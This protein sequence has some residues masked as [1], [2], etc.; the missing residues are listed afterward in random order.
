[1]RLL[2]THYFKAKDKKMKRA[3]V[4]I[5]IIALL[6]VSI[7]KYNTNS[8]T[9]ISCIKGNTASE[10][11]KLIYRLYFLGVIPLGDAV[12]NKAQ[13]ETIAGVKVY[14]LNASASTLKAYSKLGSASAVIDSYID[15]NTGNPLLFKQKVVSPGKEAAD[16]EVVYDQKNNVMTMAGERRTILPDTQDPLSLIFNIRRLNLANVGKAEYQMNTN[17]KNYVF[18]A[19]FREKSIS[20]GGKQ[21]KLAI[22][23]STIKRKDKNPYHQTSISVVFLQDK[24]NIPLSIRVFSSGILVSARLVGAE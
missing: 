10:P 4:V 24:Y 13:K 21:Y 18:S 11:A 14:H 15:I 1:L 16:K 20:S 6:V 9:A 12:F 5:A 7:Y 2:Y 8:L 23:D 3:A 19:F 17:Q 22:M